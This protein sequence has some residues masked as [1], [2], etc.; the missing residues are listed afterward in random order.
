MRKIVVEVESSPDFDLY[1]I[2]VAIIEDEGDV[3]VYKEF[4]GEL[5]CES[6]SDANAVTAAL[7]NLTLPIPNTN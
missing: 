5:I 6:A 3:V 1:V 7:R 2:S 4:M